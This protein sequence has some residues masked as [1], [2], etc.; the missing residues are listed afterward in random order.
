MV[1][2]LSYNICNSCLAT[3][4]HKKW[5]NE[6]F[7]CYLKNKCVPKDQMRLRSVVW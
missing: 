5:Q 3:V 4:L 2:G 6:L 7:F 1:I